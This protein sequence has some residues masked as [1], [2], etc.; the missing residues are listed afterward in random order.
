[1][2]YVTQCLVYIGDDVS[3]EDTYPGH[4]PWPHTL[5]IPWPH[6]HNLQEPFLRSLMPYLSG[7]Y[8][9]HIM[10]PHCVDGKSTF[11]PIQLEAVELVSSIGT[12]GN[13]SMEPVTER[14]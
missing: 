3:T 14:S 1:M 4:I 11:C 13:Q 8:G 12:Y 5:A 2:R 10:L 9:L 7:M 6:N